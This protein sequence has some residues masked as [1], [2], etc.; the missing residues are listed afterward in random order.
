MNNGPAGQEEENHNEIVV[1]LIIIQVVVFCVSCKS[2]DNRRRPYIPSHHSSFSIPPHYLYGPPGCPS[3]ARHLLLPPCPSSSLCLR[4]VHC[5]WMMLMAKMFLL[6]DIRSV[7]PRTSLPPSLLHHIVSSSQ[8]SAIIAQPLCQ[9]IAK[10]YGFC[11]TGGGIRL[12]QQ[13]MRLHLLRGPPK[14]ALIASPRSESHA[15]KSPS[16]YL[17]TH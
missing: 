6:M 11:A 3:F 2:T 14:F 15:N 4:K 17:C 9:T 7:F 12:L 1:S 5:Q 16:T 10:Q 13:L 8:S